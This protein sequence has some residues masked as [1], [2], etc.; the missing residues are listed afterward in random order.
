NS[1]NPGNILAATQSAGIDQYSGN[2]AWSLGTDKG[3]S[4]AFPFPGAA[5]QSNPVPGIT[6][7]GTQVAIAPTDATVAYAFVT[8]QP[9]ESPLG[10]PLPYEY[11]WP[12]PAPGLFPY[13]LMTFMKSTDGGKTWTTPGNRTLQFNNLQDAPLVVDNL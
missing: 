3:L 7:T 5:Y 13:Y 12:F 10:W 9:V 4:V 2:P 8:D 11:F 1:S 6:A